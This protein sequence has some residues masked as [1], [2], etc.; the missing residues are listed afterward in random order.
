MH[1]ATG[2]PKRRKCLKT[3][4]LSSFD[5]NLGVS[6]KHD[7]EFIKSA[8]N[9]LTKTL[10][11]IVFIAA[12]S[13]SIRRSPVSY[14]SSRLTAGHVKFRPSIVS[15]VLDFRISS[16]RGIL[17]RSILLGRAT[18][19]CYAHATIH[20]RENA[21]PIICGLMSRPFDETVRQRS[22]T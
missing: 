1:V 4:L 3:A 12:R 21:D 7:V 17:I 15:F 11:F 2:I 20:A 18:C 10:K 9:G 6:T 22:P 16:H 13:I 19:V 14:F 5:F 8:L